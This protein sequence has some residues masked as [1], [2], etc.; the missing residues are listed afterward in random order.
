MADTYTGVTQVAGLVTT[1][2]DTA[3]ENQNRH[4]PLLR[5]LPD[6]HLVS[7]THAGSTYRLFK[8][9]DLAES[10]AELTET[11]DPDAVAV[12]NTTPLDVAFREFGRI[13]YKT[14]KLDLTSL[15]KVD[16]I[17]VDLLARDQ[18]VSLDAEVGTILYAATN[19]DWAGD[20]TSTATI[21][22]TDLMKG[23]DVRTIV[24]RLRTNAA[25]PRRGELYWCGIHPHVALDLRTAT[26][27]N[28]WR[29]DHKYTSPEGFWAG[30]TGVYEGAFFVESARMKVANGGTPATTDIYQ[31][32][33]AG[34]QALAEVVWEMPH[35]VIGDIP[36][37]K[38][39][40]HRP[41]AWYGALNW[42]IYR[43]ENV[44]RLESAASLGVNGS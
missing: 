28:E 1:A 21:D 30:E 15:A 18:A 5:A 6:K 9:N 11:V 16:P 24:T 13:V 20:A 12:P 41:F 43:Q 23:Q 36:V 33:F 38:L 10:S 8:Y 22:P 34:R 17:I 27:A 31:T 35:T 29:D 37:D 19:V 26:G 14:K 44:Y 3:V 32:V 42:A 39:Q 7:P 4:M 2:Y 25:S 40:R